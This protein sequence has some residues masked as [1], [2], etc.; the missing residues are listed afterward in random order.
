MP[1]SI[2]RDKIFNKL[3]A[4]KLEEQALLLEA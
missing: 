2:S 4:L 3:E 1:K